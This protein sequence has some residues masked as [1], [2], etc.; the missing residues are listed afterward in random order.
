MKETLKT[1]KRYAAYLYSDR[2]VDAARRLLHEER[3]K[4]DMS[5]EILAE[6]ATIHRSAISHY[7]NGLRQPSLYAFIKL[8]KA[9]AIK[10]S[11]LLKMAEDRLELPQEAT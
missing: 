6:R 4:R 9:M 11:A 1:T 5:Q 8:A 3:V 2:L 10:P 7:E